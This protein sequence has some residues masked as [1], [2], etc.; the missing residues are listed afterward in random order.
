MGNLRAVLFNQ[1]GGPEE[2]YE[3]TLPVPEAKAG[4]V[5]V[6]VEASSVNGADL[7]LR[8][9]SLALLT[10]RRLP[11]QLGIDFVGSLVAAGSEAALGRLAIGDQ[12]WGTECSCEVRQGA[13]VASQC[14]LR[15]RKARG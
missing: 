9:G 2:L 3:S 1:Y 8:S 12:V 5:M 4:D 15:R 10:G 11:R 13:W 14:N 7:L 6:R